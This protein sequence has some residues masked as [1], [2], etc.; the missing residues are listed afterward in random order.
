M[1]EIWKEIKG[2]ENY[3]V[4][5]L[6]NVRS[7]SSIKKGGL[8]KLDHNRY[9]YL[10]I[11]LSKNGKRKAFRVHRLVAEA[12]IENRHLKSQVNHKDA[13]KHNN[14]VSNLEWTTFDENRD[15]AVKK[16]IYAK[17]LNFKQVMLIKKLLKDTNRTQENIAK[18]FNI[19]R[20]TISNIKRGITH[21]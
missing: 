20:S 17:K 21:A 5:N 7:N 14:K 11:K 6:G 19:H 2:Y 10:Y 13:N 18:L 16:G 15:H 12:F 9:G 8:L 4:S 1:K 3:E